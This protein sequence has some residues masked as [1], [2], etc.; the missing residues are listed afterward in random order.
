[1]AAIPSIIITRTIQKPKV[2]TIY[3][4]QNKPFTLQFNNSENSKTTIVA[5]NNHTD[6]IKLGILLE[7]HK[8]IQHDWPSNIFDNDDL[9]S[10][11]TIYGDTRNMHNEDLFELIIEEWDNDHLQRYCIKNIMD[12]LYINNINDPN[13]EAA[14]KFYLSGQLH[15]ID[16]DINFYID[17]F[18]N[19]I[20]EL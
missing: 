8:R 7:N 10:S 20:K 15:K 16:A 12:I 3:D 11:F 14:N 9:N 1:M 5:F 17:V 2:Y 18:N 13:D 19:K 6:A 4:K